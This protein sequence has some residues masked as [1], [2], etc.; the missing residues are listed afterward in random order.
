M[1]DKMA[2]ELEGIHPGDNRLGRYDHTHLAITPDRLCLGVVG[3]E[4]FD[5]APES[6]GKLRGVCSN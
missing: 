2:A 3:V 4:P 1:C 6:L 5:R